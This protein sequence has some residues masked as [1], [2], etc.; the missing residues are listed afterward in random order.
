MRLCRRRA[1]APCRT[2]LVRVPATD[3]SLVFCETD[4]VAL[5]LSA[6]GQLFRASLGYE[7]SVERAMVTIDWRLVSG[8]CASGAM[9]DV[10]TKDT[11]GNMRVP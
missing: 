6:N 11:T 10:T 1:P 9:P 4:G 2:F 3:G 7:V 5:I 8:G